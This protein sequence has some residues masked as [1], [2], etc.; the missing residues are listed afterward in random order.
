MEFI[1]R[2]IEYFSTYDVGNLAKDIISFL[3][4]FFLITF[5]LGYAAKH[6]GGWYSGIIVTVIV[7]VAALTLL[8]LIREAYVWYIILASALIMTVVL[9]SV[10]M[11]R[12][13]YK[14][15]IK[16]EY[17]T[18]ESFTLTPEEK[19]SVISSIVK[20]CQ[21][22]SKNDTGALIII[23]NNSISEQIV[24][25]GTIMNADLSS[26]LIETLFYPKCP[27][28]DGAILITGN[29]IVAAGCYLPLT[30]RPNLPKELGTRHR[31]AIGVS[32]ADPTVTAV[33]VS[34]ESGII[35]VMHD[36]MYK[37]Y[38][39][40]E[41]LTQALSGAYGI[42]SSDFWSDRKDLIV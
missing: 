19:K 17:D 33:V 35:S 26:E 15:A 40:A 18:E 25:S 12:D 41:S 10:E 36:G 3:A 20:S 24:D 39:D 13:L 32:E 7:I 5:I 22:L 37:R 29:K 14:M 8:G 9:F 2:I 28:H 11:R 27:L 38:M 16:Q 23:C 30:Q 42:A 6:H 1:N 4:T 21:S 31:A 34:E